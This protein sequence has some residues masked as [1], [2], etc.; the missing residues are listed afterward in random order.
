MTVPLEFRL[1]RGDY[2]RFPQLTAE[3]VTLP[4]DVIVP[5]GGVRF[6]TQA[7]GQV[8]VV[9]PTVFDPVG[10]GV[11]S[12]LARPGGYVTG[13]TLMTAELDAKRM[14]LL[15]TAFPQITAVSALVDPSNPPQQLM[16]ERIEQ[17]AKSMGLGTVGRV[18]APTVEV[19]RSLQP[20]VFS[21]AGAVIVVGSGMFWNYRQYI[22]SLVNKARLPAIYPEREYADDGGLMVYG[23]NVP[24]N[25]RRA[26]EYVDRILKGAKPGDLP[27]QEPVTFDFIVNLKTARELNLTLP[28]VILARATE[29]IE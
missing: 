29:V 7:S 22:V 13:F 27:I 28:P 17:A 4:V 19:L 5:D 2:T 16:F 23:A 10:Q 18:D 6:V 11:A 25:F 1:A 14:E 15:R 24:D 3:L 9:V 21:G 20:A 12:S 8:P 26:A